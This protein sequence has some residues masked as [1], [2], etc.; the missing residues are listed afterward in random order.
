MKLGGV[1]REL[2]NKA[3]CKIMN[4]VEGKSIVVLVED[5]QDGMTCRVPKHL[6]C[7]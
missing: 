1:G 6:A 2:G 4:G 3:G 7:V 5:R